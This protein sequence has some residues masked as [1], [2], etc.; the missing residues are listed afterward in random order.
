VLGVKSVLLE[1][2]AE[3]ARRFL[4]AGLVDRIALFVSPAIVGDDG[5]ASP[6]TEDAIPDGFVRRS[7][8]TF[9]ADRL[10]DHERPL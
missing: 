5:I 1:G 6:V 3:T 9:G 7:E 10:I 8:E 4:D 2:G